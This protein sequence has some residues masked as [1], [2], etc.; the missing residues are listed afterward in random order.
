MDLTPYV[1]SLREDL[2]AAAAVGDE[3]TRRA[4]T[5]LAGAIEPAARLAL[6]NALSDLAAEVTGVDFTPD[7]APRRPGDPARIVASGELAAR[8][9]GW[10][11]RH[12]LRDMIASAWEAQQAHAG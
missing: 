8:D 11:M 7:V 6:M 4:A 3:D 1:S 2:L 12:S 10:E 9:L 5:L